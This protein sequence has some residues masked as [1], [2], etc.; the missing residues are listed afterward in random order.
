MPSLDGAVLM[1]ED[2]RMSD[3]QEFARNLTSLLQVP[4]AKGVQGLVIGRFQVASRVTRSLLD[5]IIA[6]QERLAGLPV[7]ANVD[8]GHTDP[9][10][11][12]PVGGQATVNVGASTTVRIADS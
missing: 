1:V 4:E 12:F 8:F 10:I 11:T 6:R 2:D 7:L 5:Q 3:A 9:C